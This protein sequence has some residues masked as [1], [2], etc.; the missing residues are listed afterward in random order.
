MPLGELSAELRMTACCHAAYL[1]SVDGE[2]ETLNDGIRRQM[3]ERRE[4]ARQHFRP[5]TLLG[6]TEAAAR[7]QIEALGGYLVNRD[8]PIAAS[9]D[10]TRVQVEVVDGYVV[11]AAAG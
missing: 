6:L 2:D 7:A 11:F 4:I 8:G 10:F 3:S 9:I 1:R 5:Q